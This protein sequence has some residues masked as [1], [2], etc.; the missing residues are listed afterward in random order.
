MDKKEIQIEIINTR[1]ENAKTYDLGKGKFRQEI[2]IGAVHYKD[3]YKDAKEQFKDIDLTWKDNKITKAPYTLE[4][5][6][7]KIIVLDKKTGQTGTIEITDIGDTTLSAASFDSVKT[8]EIVKDVDVEIIPAPDSIRFQTVIKDPTALAELKYKVSGDIPIK[9]SAVDADGDSVPL[10]TSLEKGILT[11]SVDA[12]SFTSLDEKKTAIKYPIKID[13]TLTIQGSGADTTI[14]NYAAT[15][16]YGSETYLKVDAWHTSIWNS[17]I[18]MSLSSLPA[19]AELASAT[20][21]LYYYAADGNDPVGKT[22]TAYKV[23][24]AD[25]VEAQATWNIYKT[26]NGWGTAGCVNTTTDIDTSLT[27]TTT[28]PTGASR[29]AWMNLN[30]ADIVADAVTNSLDF[31][32]RLSMTAGYCWPFFYSKEYATDTSLR[33][34]LVIEY[35]SAASFIPGIMRHNFI[36]SFTGG[37]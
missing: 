31:N 20:L 11:E 9:Y 23:R 10:I 1:T 25:W 36:P 13:P 8:T 32:I 14:S 22:L 12:K 4:R 16:N 34:K 18:K 30:V 27:A 24:R 35:A 19:G 6:G 33:P 15:T 26:S 28:F 5:I 21:S 17:L 37:K 2:C 3:D 7:N 29:P